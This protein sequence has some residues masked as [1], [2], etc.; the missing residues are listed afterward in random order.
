MFA[1]LGQGYISQVEKRR[2]F[3]SWLVNPF[4]YYYTPIKENIYIALKKYNDST[5]TDIY[6]YTFQNFQIRNEN[7]IRSSR[8][9]HTRLRYSGIQ[10]S[11]CSVKR[12]ISIYRRGPYWSSTRLDTRCTRASWLSTKEIR[13]TARH[14]F[15]QSS[16]PRTRLFCPPWNYRNATDSQRSTFHLSLSL[17]PTLLSR[18][19]ALCSRFSKLYRRVVRRTVALKIGKKLNSRGSIQ[20]I[21]FSLYFILFCH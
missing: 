1:R 20:P 7:I 8:S 15:A 9:V 4:Q 2:G 19:P 3:R 6:I 16:R 11:P 17:R 21:L 18:W 5:S 10:W 14:R 13:F 12:A